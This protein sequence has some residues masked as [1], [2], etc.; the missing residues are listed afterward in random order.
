MAL[1]EVF[2]R[3]I[4]YEL[5]EA[6]GGVA[7]PP[8]MLVTGMAGACAGWHALQVPELVKTR[9]VLIF[10]HR[11]VG[12]SDDPGGAFS[13]ADLA[14]DAGALV[15]ALG[16]GPVDVLGPFMGGMVAQ[17]LAIADPGLVRKLVLVGTYARP[18]AK[19]RI[20]L[21]HWAHMM[22]DGV[23]F[24]SMVYQRMLW[25]LQDETLEE[26][27][28]V[29]SMTTVPAAAELPF[30]EDLVIRQFE[31]SLAHDAADRLGALPHETLILCGRHDVLTP[32]K[33]HRELADLIPH[34]QLVTL[35]Y[36][37]HLVMAESAE[38]FNHVVVQFL[39]DAR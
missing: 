7:A 17:E 31:A 28:L 5:H 29:K 9:S 20:L 25:T 3:K 13:T 14:A 6:Q 33:F 18:D 35:S 38:R 37:A 2:G 16:L 1:A 24:S 15:R 11:G 12:E 4:Y 26:E 30:S 27:D 22:G 21:K 39:D 36:G 23:P 10:D 19:R 34:A 8:L 32:P